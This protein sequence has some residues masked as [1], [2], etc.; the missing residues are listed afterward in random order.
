MPH[1]LVADGPRQLDLDGHDAA[2]AALED[3]Y[4]AT[5]AVTDGDAILTSH[6][7]RVRS[8][9]R[10]GLLLLGREDE[11][12]EELDQGRGGPGIRYGL[13]SGSPPTRRRTRPD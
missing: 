8:L 9:A 3:G 4:A 1:V 11:I 12:V 10:A 7:F 13:R 6:Q 2:I 5:D